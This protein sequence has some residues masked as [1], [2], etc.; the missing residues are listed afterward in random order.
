MLSAEPE[1]TPAENKL[2]EI[3][4]E[5]IVSNNQQFIE[6]KSL[7]YQLDEGPHDNLAETSL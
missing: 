2:K 6:C 5:I 1:L 3:E 7:D 4:K